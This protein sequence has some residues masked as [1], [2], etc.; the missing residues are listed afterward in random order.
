MEDGGGFSG[1]CVLDFAL[2][3]IPVNSP[4][5]RVLSFILAVG[6][7]AWRLLY[8]GICTPIRFYYQH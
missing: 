4:Y 5:T 7:S 6:I 8:R 2:Q 3:I 1:V